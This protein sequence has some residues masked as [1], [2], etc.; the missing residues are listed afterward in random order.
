MRQDIAVQDDLHVLVRVLERVLAGAEGHQYGIKPYQSYGHHQCRQDDIHHDYIA[1][2]AISPVV[3][4]LAQIDSQQ[5]RSSYAHQT[6]KRSAYVHERFGYRQRA[7]SQRTATVTDIDR[8]H[9]VVQR[10]GRHGNDGWKGVFPKEFMYG[11]GA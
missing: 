2:Y 9:Q 7:K 3:I 5:R 6:A 11:R 10:S 4:L 8:V 1:Q